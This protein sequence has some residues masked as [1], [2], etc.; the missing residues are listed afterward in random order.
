MLLPI[1][2]MALGGLAGKI[3]QDN[4]Q[5]GTDFDKKQLTDKQKAGHNENRDT[6]TS[7][8]GVSSKRRD[9]R[10]PDE[11]TS[12]EAVKHEHQQNNG[13]DSRGVHSDTGGADANSRD[14]RPDSGVIDS[15]GDKAGN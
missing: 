7:T 9:R 5:V 6:S 10:L 13:N 4:L 2:G 11:R 8:G 15:E 12:K 3:I 14:S 1:I